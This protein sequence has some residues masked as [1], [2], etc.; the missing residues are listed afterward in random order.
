MIAFEKYLID[1]GWDFYTLRDR[2][3]IKPKRHQIST[4]GDVCYHY[5]HKDDPVIDKINRGE[6]VWDDIT[7]KD[8]ARV[9]VVGL[10]EKGLPPTLISPRPN[11]QALN[12]DVPGINFEGVEGPID[13]RIFDHYMNRALQTFPH[14]TIFKAMFDENTYLTI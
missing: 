6:K 11:I 8:I 12:P 2:A 9:I 7:P 3:Y 13:V 10:N 5:F 14:D 1:N 4:M